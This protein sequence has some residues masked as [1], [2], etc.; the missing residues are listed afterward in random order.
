[1]GNVFLGRI[2][3]CPTLCCSS[4]KDLYL[5]KAS[6]IFSEKAGAHTCHALT[7][8]LFHF[9]TGCLMVLLAARSSAGTDHFKDSA[10]NYVDNRIT[11]RDHLVLS[12]EASGHRH[13][14]QENA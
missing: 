13:R 8:I 3:F 10:E 5:S 12:R 4:F 9:C 1:M 14:Q 7:A 6:I 2:Y 11:M